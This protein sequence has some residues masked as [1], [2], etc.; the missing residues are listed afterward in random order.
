MG[1]E[2]NIKKDKVTVWTT[3][4]CLSTLPALLRTF[5]WHGRFSLRSTGASR[6]GLALAWLLRAVGIL[7]SKAQQVEFTWHSQRV[8]DPESRRL[9][10]RVAIP[11]EFTSRFFKIYQ[12]LLAE[13]AYPDPRVRQ[14]RVL[15]NLQK[16]AAETIHQLM[17]FVEFARYWHR[18]EGI[19][20]GHLVILSP[21]AVLANWIPPKWVGEDV[22]FGCPWSRHHSLLFWVCRGIL[23]CVTHSLRWRRPKLAVPP[24]IAVAAAW[25]LDRSMRLNDLHW[26]WNSGI[27][28][29][30]IVL[31]FSWPGLPANRKV[32]AQ[33]ERLGLRCIVLNRCAIGDSPHRLWRAAPGLSV[34]IERLWQK[35][36]M[37]GW[38]VSRGKVGSWVACRVLDMLHFSEEMED[39]LSEFNVRGFFHYQD[40]GID[41]LSLACDAARVARIGHQWSNYHWPVASN[42]RLHQVY[43]AWGSSYARMLEAVGS[44]VDHILLSGCI[45]R[46]AYPGNGNVGNGIQDRAAVAAH[47]ASRVLA[48]FDTSLPCE[49]FYEFFLQRVIQDPCWGLLIKPKDNDSLPWVR[50]R[51]P[52]LQ[53]L[54]EQSLATGRVRLLNWRLSPVE[55]A[56]GADFA[57]GVDINSAII[58]AALAGYRAIHLDYVR[59]HASLLSEWA[60]FYRAGPDRLVFDDPEKLWAKLN[61]FFDKPGSESNLGMVDDLLLRDIDPFRDGRAGQRI[62]EYV[63]W[64]LEGLDQGLERDQ[65]LEQADCRYAD[66]CGAE[67]VVRGLSSFHVS[68][69]MHT[70]REGC[71]EVT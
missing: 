43:F 61:C 17:A 63:R 59:L 51:L 32:V 49:R 37:F 58:V 71:A 5:L 57:V 38:G 14:D 47:G 29:E 66:K 60:H 62:G 44:C 46:G 20:A 2:V 22:E 50:R 9:L 52:E 21:S 33:A 15:T 11:N 34:S 13:L 12:G 1:K 42:A 19:Q 45:V 35:L 8:D 54:Y 53:A 31:C 39:F 36:R 6:G 69:S 23:R 41:Y 55:A 7:D 18:V 30:R 28:A 70:E 10:I 56:A 67:M 64:Y 65:A 16:S 68:A 4:L 24:S 26:W 3:N 40:A 25:G 27:P 48:L